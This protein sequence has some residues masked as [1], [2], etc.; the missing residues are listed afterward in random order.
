[1]PNSN[2]YYLAYPGSLESPALYL[3]V[4]Y[5][6]VGGLQHRNLPHGAALLPRT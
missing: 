2:A 1:M 3:S 5:L 4:G 6:D